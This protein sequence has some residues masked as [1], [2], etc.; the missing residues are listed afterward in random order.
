M[1]IERQN[2]TGPDRLA[3]WVI[4]PKGRDLGLRIKNG[5]QDSILFISNTVDQNIAPESNIFGFDTLGREIKRRFHHFSGH[6]FIFSTGIAVRLI[7]PLLKTKMT[8]PAVV[9]VDDN[10]TH[11]VSLIS[12]HIGGANALTHKIA[13]ILH[14]RPVITTATDTNG[15]PAI[16][17]IAKEKKLY[18]ETPRNIKRI[19]MAFLMGRPVDIHDPLGLIE[20]ELHGISLVKGSPD[21]QSLEKIYCS[22]EAGPVSR[23]TMILRPRVLSVGIGC[24]RGTGVDDIYDF[25]ALVFREGNL[26]MHSIKQ[27]ASIDL[28][29]NEPGLLSLSEKMNLPLDFHTR[30]ALNAVASIETP[31]P[32]AEKHVGAKSVSEASAILSAGHGRLI[33]TKKKNK[34]VTIAVAI[35]K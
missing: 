25:L 19:N 29:K 9:V 2:N 23:E 5:V 3:V 16:D 28:K 8:D 22:H 30:E 26:S 11:V 21:E 34:D 13:G 12:G 4:T 33:I 32:M 14:A 20:N 10:G 17:V 1:A 15:L 6:V 24:N 7:A 18:I 27:L 35:E 31:S